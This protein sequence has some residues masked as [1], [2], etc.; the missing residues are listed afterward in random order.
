MLHTVQ[1]VLDRPVQGADA[2]VGTLADLLFDGFTWQVR[3]LVVSTGN[4]LNRHQVLLAP[5][6][7]QAAR[8][9]DAEQ[10]VQVPLTAERI[11][12]SPPVDAIP[13]VSRREERALAEYFG[14]S[15]YWS[16][17]ITG[18]PAP[19]GADAVSSAA[20]ASEDQDPD[21]RSAKEVLGYFLEA[22]DGELGH[23]E[24]FVLDLDHWIIRYLL[25]KTR[26][27]LP[28]RRVLISPAW[29]EAIHWEDRHVR[30]HLSRQ[31]IEASPE[32]HGDQ[33]LERSYEAQLHESY[34]RPKYWLW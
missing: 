5:E 21:L 7:F 4:W 24:D 14:W 15:G 3:Y 27:W 9:D 8:W 18:M 30:V 19:V 20:T 22:T 31:Q 6:L 34:G 26:N 10:A 33:P 17:G 29:T 28:G 2:K 23:V 12:Q 13:A 1:H 11:E 32:Y 25:V 16:R